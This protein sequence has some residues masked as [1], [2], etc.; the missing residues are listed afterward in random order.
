MAVRQGTG[1]TR[2]AGGALVACLVAVLC[3]AAV[4]AQ[5]GGGWYD[6]PGMKKC[7]EFRADGFDFKVY[8]SKKSATQDKLRCKKASS[9]MKAWWKGAE[10]LVSY[11]EDGDFYTLARHP[12]WRCS[13][14]AGGG[15][16]T[17]GK[18]IAGYQNR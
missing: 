13:S 15:S 18:Q 6:W 5:A 3:L 16:C 1:R 4:P 2:L 9:V 12:K 8:A 11:H 17:H 7:G 10:R 14:G